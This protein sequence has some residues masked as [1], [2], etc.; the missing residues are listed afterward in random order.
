MY[1]LVGPSETVRQLFRPWAVDAAALVTEFGGATALLFLLSLWYWLGDRRNV[2]TVVS[3]AFVA[4]SLVLVFKTLLGLPRPP[5]S[6]QAVSYSGDPYGFPSGHAAA[7]V[8]V[9]GGLAATHERFDPPTLVAVGAVVTAIA[10]SRVVIG[11]HYLGDVLVGGALGVLLLVGLWTTVGRRPR[12][13]FGIAAGISVVAVS[14]ET[15]DSSMA[16]G[17]SLGGLMGVPLLKRLPD[18]Q[19]VGFRVAIAAAGVVSVV[20]LTAV[21]DLL[22]TTVTTVAGNTVLVVG[23]LA[24]PVVADRVPIGS[25]TE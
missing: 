11:V 1:R 22:S 9:Y 8:V 2:A 19:P 18:D 14:I 20:A 16:L 23:I 17:G 7:A 13:A 12:L 3:Y 4:L 10:L 21:I 15:P 6:L 24:L 5:G 25:N